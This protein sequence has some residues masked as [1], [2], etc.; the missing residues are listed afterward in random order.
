MAGLATVFIITTVSSRV[1][2]EGIRE[3]LL[4]IENGTAIEG[5]Q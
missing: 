3:R 2:V 1:V 4:K 5:M